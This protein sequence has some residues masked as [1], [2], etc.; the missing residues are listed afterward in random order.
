MPRWN[1]SDKDKLYYKLKPV[2]DRDTTLYVSVG[3]GPEG[4]LSLRPVIGRDEALKLIRMMPEIEAKSYSN[5]KE[6]VQICREILYSEDQ[7]E[8]IAL[9]KGIFKNGMKRKKSGKTLS[10]NERENQ[11]TAGAFLYGE[12]AVVLG[13]P[14]DQVEDYIAGELEK[15]PA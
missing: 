10:A 8:R 3:G 5:Y 9:M 12:L 13:I 11:K 6:Q 2:F 15:G 14:L 4:K 7:K 1:F